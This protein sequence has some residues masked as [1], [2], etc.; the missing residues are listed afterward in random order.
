MEIKLMLLTTHPLQQ[1]IK[2]SKGKRKMA[3]NIWFGGGGRS[4][5]LFFRSP[6]LGIY[7]RNPSVYSLC[8]RHR[9]PNHWED[10]LKEEL[11]STP[12]HLIL[13]LPMG[14]SKPNKGPMEEELETV[15][16]SH[17]AINAHIFQSNPGPLS[18]SLSCMVVQKI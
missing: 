17:A 4:I 5:N 10:S 6:R 1:N 14:A 11:I 18:P 3:F 8:T 12:R 7:A 15:S 13:P 16:G 9:C 2:C